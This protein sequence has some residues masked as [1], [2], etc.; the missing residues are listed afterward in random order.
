MRIRTMNPLH[1]GRGWLKNNNRPGDPCGSL[2]INAF[3]AIAFGSVSKPPHFVIE[4]FVTSEN[5]LDFYPR[6][7]FQRTETRSLTVGESFT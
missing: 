4:R 6:Y 2:R 5:R 1:R 7:I 3:I